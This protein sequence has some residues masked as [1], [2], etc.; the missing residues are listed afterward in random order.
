[1]REMEMMQGD[2]KPYRNSEKRDIVRDEVV[3]EGLMG[4][5]SLGR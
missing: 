2:P 1:M 4:N 5:W 3:W